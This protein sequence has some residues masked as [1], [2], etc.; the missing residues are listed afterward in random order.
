MK[1]AVTTQGN[2]IFQHFGQCRTFTVFSVENGVI[3]EKE[4]IDASKSG[5]SALAG[6]LKDTG[7]EVLICGGI[8]DGAKK[9]LSSVGIKLISGVEGTVENA[10]AGYLS[11]SLDDLGGTCSHEKHD[12]DHTC[13][14]ENHR[15]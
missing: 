3:Q 4:A 8:G 1:I 2:Q 6:F 13:N 9:M 5:H 15:D 10:V 7:V 14:C 11:G 12:Q